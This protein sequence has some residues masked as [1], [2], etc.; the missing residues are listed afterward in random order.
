MKRK[1]KS[2][3]RPKRPFEK[4]RIMEENEI[5]K[6]FGLKNKL[7]I[8]KA[9]ARIK[10]MRRKAKSLISS[11][12][13]E[14]KG[15]FERLNKIGLRVNSISD[16]LSL[17]KKDYLGRRLQTVVSKK[18]HLTPKTARQLVTHKHVLVDGEI[19]NVP[20]YVVPVDLEDKISLKI[21]TKAKKA[22]VEDGA[23]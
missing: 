13:E 10:S 23:E 20:S 8:W 5:R 18:F 9:E 2:Y 19:V 14:Q 1:H 16:V 11:D 12:S 6:E 4:N 7:E 17:D 15:L 3:S 22:E 21:K